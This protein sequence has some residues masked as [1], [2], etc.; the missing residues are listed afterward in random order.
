MNEQNSSETT[1]P[2]AAQPLTGQGTTWVAIVEHDHGTNVAVRATR[3]AAMDEVAAHADYW[4][5][6]EMDGEPMPEG[7]EEKIEAYFERMADRESWS[8]VEADARF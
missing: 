7:R 1:A 2:V 6:T 8:V 5:D 3:E 4:W